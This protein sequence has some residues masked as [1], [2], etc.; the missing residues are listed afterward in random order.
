[1]KEEQIKQFL[2]SDQ[3]RKRI[4]NHGQIKSILEMA[5]LNMKITLTINLT[6]ES[7]TLI[8]RETYESIRQLGDALWWLN[9]YEP[10]NHE[11]SIEILK[12]IQIKDNVKLNY[13]YRFKTIR[14]DANYRGFKV[15]YLQAKE[16]LD[17]WQCCSKEIINSIE[18]RLK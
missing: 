11:I 17:F 14:N 10:R 12:E 8:F 13:L 1:M 5:K 2:I 16:I 18:S 7:A 4:V 9:G 15:S 6:E 3:L